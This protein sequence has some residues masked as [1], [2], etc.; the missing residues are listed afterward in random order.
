[1]LIISLDDYHRYQQLNTTAEM[2]P[3]ELFVH[4]ATASSNGVMNWDFPRMIASG[5]LMTIGSNW[6]AVPDPSLLGAMA[7]IVET[8]GNGDK[9]EGGELLCRM[10]T[11]NGA[12][13][14]GK[15]HILGSIEVGKTANFIVV[16]RD[17][18]RGEFEG[19]RVVRTYFEG[20]KVWDINA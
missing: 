13:A 3:A 20:E 4:P 17:L 1:M 18:S 12:M 19:A 16:D 8:V 5:A 11:L 9:I 14:V 6:G 15:D 10:L 7:K 2:S